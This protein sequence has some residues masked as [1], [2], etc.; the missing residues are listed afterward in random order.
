MSQKGTENTFVPAA[1]RLAAERHAP[2]APEWGYVTIILTSGTG[3]ILHAAGC[4]GAWA[5]AHGAEWTDFIEGSFQEIVEAEY[6]GHL[7]DDP[8]TTWLDYRDEFIIKPCL[9]KG[10]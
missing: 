6:A 9:P 3:Y 7:R 5:D 1:T 2:V 4:S 8:T 10:I